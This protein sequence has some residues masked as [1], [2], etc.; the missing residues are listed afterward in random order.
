MMCQW[1]PLLDMLGPEIR[2]LI[3]EEE[4]KELQELRLRLG[5]KPELNYG[6]RQRWGDKDVTREELDRFLNAAS[7]YSPWQTQTAARGYITV[8]G[9][10]RIGLCGPV[11]RDAENI[12]GIRGPDSVCIRIARDV[13]G[14]AKPFRRCE[15]STLILGP[16]GWGKTTL[17]R[18]LARE[19]A[20]EVT[21]VVV[22]E[23][24]ELFP[25]GVRRGKRMDVLGLCGK[26]QGVEMAMLTMG[27]EVI[28]VDEITAPE[29]CDALICASHCGVRILATA[30]GSSVDDLR[31]RPVYRRLL[32]N[33]VFQNLI[34][35]RKDRSSVLERMDLCQ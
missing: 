34:L 4:R 26:R 22:D 6:H 18:D 35:L 10:H 19:M 23:R 30:H 9:G 8:A 32:E 17:L 7:R 11:I 5:A 16:P 15:G 1:E 24:G 20:E 14:I 27:P 13:T 12:R 31:R 21:T 2:R 28:A 3:G 33:A 29:D 25:K